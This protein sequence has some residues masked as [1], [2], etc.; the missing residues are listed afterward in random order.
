MQNVWS[1][2]NFETMRKKT[3]KATTAMDSSTEKKE[4][5]RKGA[6]QKQIPSS[7]A[8]IAPADDMFSASRWTSKYRCWKLIQTNASL[9]QTISLLSSHRAHKCVRLRMHV[10]DCRKIQI[11]VICT[12]FLFIRFS[13]RVCYRHKFTQVLVLTT[14]NGVCNVTFAFTWQQKHLLN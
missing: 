14:K 3:E 10:S 2:H 12:L 6:K 9:R 8:W 7:F 4:Q 1:T 11:D 13:S 5:Q